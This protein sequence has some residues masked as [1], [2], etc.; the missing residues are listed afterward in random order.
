MK[1]LDL[2]KITLFCFETREPLLAEWAIKKCLSKAIFKNIVLMTDLSLVSNKIPEIN[3]VQ[4]PKISSLEHYSKFMITELYKYVSGTHVL[5]IQWDSFITNKNKW[6]DDFISYDYIGAIW[7]HHS[8]YPVGNGGFSLRSQKLI[9]ALKDSEVK[10]GHP[11]DYYICVEN[12]QLLENKYQIKF[13]PVEIANSFSIERS[14]WS[15][16]FGF[17]GFFN[18]AYVLNENELKEF[19]NIIPASMLNNLDT[20]DLLDL[21]DEKQFKDVA[22]IIRKKISF[23][24]KFRYIY[25]KNKFKFFLEYF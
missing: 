1:L 4:A 23:K 25:I 18:F 7:P 11:E 24:W 9:E 8:K 15:S 10:I 13:A 20:Y 14:K 17:H 19:L 6:E 22:K 2:S 3:Y 12:R 5:V 16:A 21:V